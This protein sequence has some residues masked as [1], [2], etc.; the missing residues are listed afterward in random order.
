MSWVRSPSPAPVFPLG[1]VRPPAWSGIYETRRSARSKTPRVRPQHGAL[2]DAAARG[3][4]PPPS[5][6]GTRRSFLHRFEI[7]TPGLF[8]RHQRVPLQ[9]PRGSLLTLTRRLAAGRHPLATKRHAGATVQRKQTPVGSPKGNREDRL[10]TD[11]APTERGRYLPLGVDCP[12][13][14]HNR[15]QERKSRPHPTPKHEV[16]P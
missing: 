12:P 3:P 16:E 8:R 6:T 2:L 4:R 9:Q 13:G 1:C 15:K 10:R 14:D 5:R 11:H 7:H